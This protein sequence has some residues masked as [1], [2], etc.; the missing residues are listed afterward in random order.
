MGGETRKCKKIRKKYV[1]MDEEEKIK[2]LKTIMELSLDLMGS[3]VGSYDVKL[4][5]KRLF[6]IVIDSRLL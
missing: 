2:M 6:R 1:V 5:L 4:K 3:P